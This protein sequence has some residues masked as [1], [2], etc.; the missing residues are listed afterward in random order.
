MHRAHSKCYTQFVSFDTLVIL[1]FLNQN[2]TLL[3]FFC[4]VVRGDQFLE[5]FIFSS[6]QLPTKTANLLYYHSMH[7]QVCEREISVARPIIAAAQTKK[8]FNPRSFDPSK[9]LN[10]GISYEQII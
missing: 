7:V 8:K 9:I 2:D 3:L 10:E 1:A 6:L 4:L 5:I